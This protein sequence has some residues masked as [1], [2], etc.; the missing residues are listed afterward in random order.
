M[1][2]SPLGSLKKMSTNEYIL[3]TDCVEDYTTRNKLLLGGNIKS[4]CKLS[5]NMVL[6]D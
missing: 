5:S 4:V 3:N 6:I 1:Y 2:K